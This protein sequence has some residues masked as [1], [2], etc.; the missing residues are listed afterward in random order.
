MKLFLKKLFIS[1]SLFFCLFTFISPSIVF[2]GT[3][4]EASKQ[5]T[6]T[7]DKT[8]Q[9]NEKAYSEKLKTFQNFWKWLYAITWPLIIIAGKFMEN[10]IIYWSFIWMDVLLWKIWNIMR[11]FANYIIW[12]V[13]IFSIWISDII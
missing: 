8:A 7:K 6:Q 5:T 11:T 2:A 3:A 9:D 10:K 4:A 12:L 1:L 13:L